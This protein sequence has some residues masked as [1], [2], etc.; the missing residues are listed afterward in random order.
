[1]LAA[2]VGLTLA[3]TVLF[4][5]LEELKKKSVICASIEDSEDAYNWLRAWLLRQP[6]VS[7]CTQVDISTTS[8]RNGASDD[9]EDVPDAERV[10][11]YFP[12]PGNHILTFQGVWLLVTVVREEHREHG[13]VYKTERLRLTLFTTDRR[14]LSN[15]IDEARSSYL[16]RMKSRVS[17]YSVC[18][19]KNPFWEMIGSRPIRPPTSVV[20]DR[21]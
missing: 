7:K 21:G 8:W 14:V 9:D 19:R 15:L 11:Y 20:L 4:F 16:E 2:G 3:H 12:A 17:I 13:D 6:A 10:V 1:M 5:I 18:D